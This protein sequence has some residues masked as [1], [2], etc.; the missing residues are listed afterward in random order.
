LVAA[1]M[2]SMRINSAEMTMSNPEPFLSEFLTTVELAAELGRNKRTLD[3]WDALGT[4]P[5]RTRMG[6][7][8]LYRRSSV[9]KWLAAQ[10]NQA[11]I[12][13]VADGA[14]RRPAAARACAGR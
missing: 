10:E 7:T 9:Q 13:S 3:R 14:D 2:I 1:N 11:G 8:V 4:G 5:P 6:R 12:V